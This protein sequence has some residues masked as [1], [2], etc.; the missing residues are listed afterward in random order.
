MNA[1]D[2]INQRVETKVLCVGQEHTRKWILLVMVIVNIMELNV[3][4][5][6]HAQTKELPALRD[7][8]IL[9]VIRHV[10]INVIMTVIFVV[11]QRS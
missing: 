4:T 11:V 8:N 10:L 1:V 5:P 2:H 7:V 3:V 9:F 6:E